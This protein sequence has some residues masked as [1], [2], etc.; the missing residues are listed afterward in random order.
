MVEFFKYKYYDFSGCLNFIVN[1]TNIS[2]T[3]L[4]NVLQ[5]MDLDESE[6]E[7]ESEYDDEELEN[8]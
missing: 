8:E 5:D 1:Q 7:Y 2:I 6:S 4:T 3:T